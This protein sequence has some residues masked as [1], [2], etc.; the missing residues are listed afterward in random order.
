[1]TMKKFAFV[2]LMSVA[3]VAF[4]SDDLLTKLDADK[5]GAVSEQEAAA[6][7]AVAGKFA[8]ADANKD[9]KLDATELAAA[10]APAP[11]AQ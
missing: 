6:D 5:D 9:G 8:E 3:A 7:A 1:M 4:A 11:A 2:A 10:A